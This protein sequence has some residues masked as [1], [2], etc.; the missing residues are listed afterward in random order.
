MNI[1]ELTGAHSGE[2]IFVNFDNVTFYQYDSSPSGDT[3]YTQ[4]YFGSDD[5]WVRVKETPLEI[6]KIIE[7]QEPKNYIPLEDFY[8]EKLNFAKGEE[9]PDCNPSECNYDC[10][11]CCMHQT[12]PC[13]G[14]DKRGG[15]K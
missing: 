4:I 6:Q 11:V 15:N 3:K 2:P 13:K 9:Q 10:D 8:E 5:Q 14:C 1:I 12:G 7:D